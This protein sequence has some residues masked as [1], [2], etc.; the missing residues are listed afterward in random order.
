MK[1]YPFCGSQFPS[2]AAMVE[3]ATPPAG[4]FVAVND[5]TSSP[6][7]DTVN[8]SPSQRTFKLYQVFS[9]GWLVFENS[10]SQPW[11]TT[12]VAVRTV[13]FRRQN[14]FALRMPTFTKL[15]RFT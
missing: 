1:K 13:Y 5:P 7:K 12:F 8:V 4:I 3:T 6:S 11:S 15:S 2:C 10:C 14:P 9:A